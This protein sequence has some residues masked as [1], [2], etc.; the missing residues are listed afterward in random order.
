M[1][2]VSF[3]NLIPYVM[4]EQIWIICFAIATAVNRAYLLVK[5]TK[6]LIDLKDLRNF[7]MMARYKEVLANCVL[8]N[9]GLGEMDK[10]FATAFLK[11]L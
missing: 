1:Q 7:F 2:A 3:G 11:S 8:F 4:S 9:N 10:Q 6:Y 5:M